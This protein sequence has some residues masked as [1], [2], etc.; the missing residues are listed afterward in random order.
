MISEA[1][2]PK[3]FWAETFNIACY[4]QNRT[5]VH[6]TNKKTSYELWNDKKPNVSYFHTFGGKCFVHNN[7]KNH[8]KTFDE[9]DDE[10]ISLGYS[11]TRK[12]FKI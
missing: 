8:L 4:T 6:K 1:S 2:L 3:K 11:S 12:K 7:R 5:M 9:R 10:G